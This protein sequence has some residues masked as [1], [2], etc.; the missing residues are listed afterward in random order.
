MGLPR[1]GSASRRLDFRKSAAPLALD[2]LCLSQLH[3]EGARLIAGSLH[4]S[5][6]FG[7]AE[8]LQAT[9]EIRRCEAAR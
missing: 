8:A 6:V 4:R 2:A 5:Q 9:D 1:N 3:F 7:D